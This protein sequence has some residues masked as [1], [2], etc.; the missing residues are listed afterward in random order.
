[1]NNE[2][3][4]IYWIGEYDIIVTNTNLSMCNTILHTKNNVTA[5]T[6]NSIIVNLPEPVVKNG[7]KKYNLPTTMYTISTYEPYYEIQ[8]LIPFTEYKL[9][10]TISNFYF[11]Q[12]SINPFVSNVIKINLSKLNAPENISVLALAPTIAVVHWMPLKKLTCVAVTYEVLWKSVSLVNGTQHKSKQFINVPKRVTD[13]RFFT[14]INLSLLVQDYLIYVRVYPSNFSDFY[15]ESLSK[16]NHIYSEPNNIT[17]SWVNI[18]SM[19]ISWISNI[20]LTVL[21]TLEYKDIVTEKWETTNYIEM[22]YNKEVIYHIEN[23]RSGTLYQFR[24]ILIYLEYEETFIWPSDKRFI[25]STRG[26]KRDILGT[27][28]IIPKKYYFLLLMLSFIVIIIIIC[29]CYFYRLHRQ[30]R[31]NDEQFLS[32]TI[33][34]I[35]LEILHEVPYRNT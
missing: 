32:S 11:D 30:R 6:T 26:S 20:N 8:N 21:S 3:P 35:E 18:N 33:T 16:I 24:L 4:L 28:G 34:D 10:F 15:N 17:L 23:L 25:F 27:A 1:M 7:C 22:N 2:K 19:N 9:K 29:V 31:S 14:K 13:G 12:L 5:T